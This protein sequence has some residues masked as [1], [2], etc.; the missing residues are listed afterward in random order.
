MIIFFASVSAVLFSALVAQRK[1]IAKLEKENSLL[2]DVYFEAQLFCRKQTR[3]NLS[4][5]KGALHKY[6][7]G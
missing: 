7:V 6:H 4:E 5:L 1:H 3:E 2:G